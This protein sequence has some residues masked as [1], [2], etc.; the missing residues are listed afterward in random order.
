MIKD[1]SDIIRKHQKTLPNIEEMDVADKFKEVYK[2][3]EDGNLVIENEMHMCTGLRKV[4]MEIANLGAL[5]IIHCIWYPDPDFD[6]PIFGA[7]IVSN[8]NIVTAAITDI[9]PVGDLEHP[10]YEE[11]EDISRMHSFKH[12]RDIPAWGEIFSPY[13]KFA[14]LETDEDKSTF[15]KV[16]DQYLDAFVGAVWKSTIDY[17]GAEQ[18][19]EAQ[20]NYC[21]NQKK[22]DKTRKIL[23]NYFGDKW[24]ENYIN[25]VLFDEP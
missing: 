19:N 9:S 11:I 2:E 1:L 12:N 18:R 15:C 23:T 21:T 17:N 22:N 3:T 4:H 24:A 25:Q 8:R 6:L 7:D 20:I 16:V 5:D 14:R 10:I 13:C